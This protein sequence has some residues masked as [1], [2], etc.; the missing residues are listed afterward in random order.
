MPSL[1]AREGTIGGLIVK[2]RTDQKCGAVIMKTS[3]VL[4]RLGVLRP[5]RLLGHFERAKRFLHVQKGGLVVGVSVF[6]GRSMH[7]V[8]VA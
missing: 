8:A 7:G 6:E 1:V 3:Q 2:E 4:L 5:L